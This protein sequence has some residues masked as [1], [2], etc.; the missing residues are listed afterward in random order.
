M[1]R[2]RKPA[3]RDTDATRE[4]LLD[5]ARQAFNED[6]FFG[7][8]SNKI[9]RAAGFAPQT[10]YRHF[11]DKTEI[12]LAVYESWWTAEVDALGGVKREGPSSAVEAARIA[13]LF[14]R[15]WRVFRRSLRHLAIVDPRV[16]AARA[17][18]REAQIARAKAIA[19]ISRSDAEWIAI[20]LSAERLCDAAADDELADL[21]IK[22]AE[23]EAMVAPVVAP[24]VGM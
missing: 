8:D 14:H 10:F 16:R 1:N 20:L 18:A 13:L 15:R 24:L 7:T 12:F 6:G 11:S 9:A 2:N 21:G 23:I 4:A 3:P 19:R 17:K 5:A 22:K